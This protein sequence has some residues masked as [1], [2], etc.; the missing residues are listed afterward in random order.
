MSLDRKAI[1]S[2]SK[3][4]REPAATIEALAETV[5]LTRMNEI[6]MNFKWRERIVHSPDTRGLR[7]KSGTG[8]RNFF[9]SIICI[10]I[11]YHSKARPSCQQTEQNPAICIEN[12][13][14]G[15]HLI[16]GRVTAVTRV[17]IMVRLSL[18]AHFDAIMALAIKM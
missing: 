11:F 5:L 6:L 16:G 7:V 1:I 13:D 2:G 14:S 15:V 8:L 18:K 10:C 17:A 3:A 12:S 4:E 9:F